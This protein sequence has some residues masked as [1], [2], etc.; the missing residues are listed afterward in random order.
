[1][2]K[3]F[4]LF[5]VDRKGKISFKNLRQI[6]NE[7]GEQL[8]DEELKEMIDEA[9]KDGDGNCA[10]CRTQITRL[11]RITGMVSQE[12]FIRIMKKTALF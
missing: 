10:Q 3:A 2:L 1:V 4:S 9:D 7:L 8:T 6:A 12:E 5:D 11:T